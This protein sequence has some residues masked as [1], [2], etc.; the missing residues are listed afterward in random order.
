[1]LLINSPKTRATQPREASAGC[2]FRNP[3][4]VSAGWL[5]EQS[6]LKGEKQG[7]AIILTVMQLYFKSRRRN[8]G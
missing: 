3:E 8:C 4:E 5:I 1:M 7:E 2:I 6:G